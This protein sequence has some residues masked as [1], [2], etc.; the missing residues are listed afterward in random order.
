MGQYYVNV[1]QFLHLCKM[2]L[3]INT[4]KNV[5]LQQKLHSYL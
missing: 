3:N 4:L 2:L 5:Y 1:N